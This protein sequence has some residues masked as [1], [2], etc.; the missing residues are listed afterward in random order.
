M[1]HSTWATGVTSFLHPSNNDEIPCTAAKKK[2]RKDFRT[3]QR[4][5]GKSF[6]FSSK[7]VE[8]GHIESHF[9]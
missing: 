4:R 5:N 1:L 9:T 3:L 2:Q 6:Y 7:N 8:K